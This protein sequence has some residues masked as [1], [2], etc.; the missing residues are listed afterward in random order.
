MSEEEVLGSAYQK[1]RGYKPTNCVNEGKT[2]SYEKAKD[3]INKDK[4][5]NCCNVG[6]DK[7]VQKWHLPQEEQKVLIRKADSGRWNSSRSITMSEEEVLGSAYQKLRGYKP[8]NCVNEGK[9]TSY[10]KARDF[11]NKDKERNCCNVGR[12]KSVQ[13]WHLPQEEQ[14]VLIR[15]ADSDFEKKLKSQSTITMFPIAD[16]C[17]DIF[18]AIKLRRQYAYAI[19][20]I[21]NRKEIVL[22]KYTDPLPDNTQETNEVVF[23]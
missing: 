17:K 18:T 22:K 5:R 4:E 14:K 6:R 16:E 7:S 15:K 3:F 8:T 2:T 21:E 10:E 12:D 19:M 20:K 13:K 23:N 9:T 11:I 1:L